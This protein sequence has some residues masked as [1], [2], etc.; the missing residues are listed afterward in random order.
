MIEQGRLRHNNFDGTQEII[1]PGMLTATANDAGFTTESFIGERQ[2]HTTVG[3]DVPYR[4]KRYDAN[5]PYDLEA[6]KSR[7]KSGNVILAPRQW[8]IDGIYLRVLQLMTEIARLHASPMPADE[9]E[10]VGKWYCLTAMLTDYV[11][12]YLDTEMVNVSA[13][14]QRCARKAVAYIEKYYQRK[15][16]V[17]EIAEA[18][19]MSVGH[20]HRIFKKVYHMGIME[21]ANRH[22]ISV[23]VSLMENRGLSLKEAAY[24]VGLEDPAYMSRLFKKVTGASY[25]DYERQEKITEIMEKDSKKPI[26]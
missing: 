11:L 18:Q 25:R 17:K 2:C 6:M 24:N 15:L 14:E 13:A 9:L 23:A 1:E 21:Y 5:T 8:K 3:V 19:E 12:Q 7:V 4:L 20:L 10:A 22:R 26:Y 16:C